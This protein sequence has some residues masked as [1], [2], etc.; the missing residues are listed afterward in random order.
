VIF[1]NP[2]VSVLPRLFIGPVAWLVWRAFS[3]WQPLGL[4]LSG[5][6]GSLTNTALVLGM[7]GV[8]ELF[9][10]TVVWAAAI[11]NGPLEAGAAALLN[12]AVVAAWR[13]IEVGRQGAAL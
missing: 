13:R 8:L 12:L 4:V 3:R 10:W 5:I 1:T 7:I 6:A 9:P 2:L 11:G